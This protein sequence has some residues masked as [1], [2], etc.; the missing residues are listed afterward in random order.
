MAEHHEAHEAGHMTWRGYV[1]IGIILTVIT[2]VEVAIFYI[3]ALAPVLVPTLLIL[4]AAKFVMV[5][6]FYMHLKS[7]SPIFSRVF[8]GPMV[9]AV[10]V[11]VG[12]VILFKV[13]PEYGG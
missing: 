13:L 3:P 12:L 2:G 1:L 9:L 10:F 6:L 5:V 11:V 8:F 7:D 4:S